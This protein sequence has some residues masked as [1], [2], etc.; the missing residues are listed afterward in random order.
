MKLKKKNDR[1]SYKNEDLLD[2]EFYEVKEKNQPNNNNKV[3]INH[4]LDNIFESIKM[5]IVKKKKIK[6]III[7]YYLSIKMKIQSKLKKI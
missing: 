5:Q 6:I 1:K 4:D 7:I 3:N 2:M